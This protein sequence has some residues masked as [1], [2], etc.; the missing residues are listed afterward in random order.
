MQGFNYIAWQLCQQHCDDWR[1]FHL[2]CHL[3]ER[4]HSLDYF[5][6]MQGL[7]RDLCGIAA[8]VQE[9]FP[10]LTRRLQRWELSLDAVLTSWLVCLFTAG[11][12]PCALKG[13]LL[14]FVA[15]RGRPALLQLVLLGLERLSK[16]TSS[17][18]SLEQLAESIRDAEQCFASIDWAEKALRV[19]LPPA[20]TA[21]P[22]RSFVLAGRLSLR[23]QLKPRHFT[24]IGASLPRSASPLRLRAPKSPSAGQCR[25]ED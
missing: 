2:L 24:R 6:G 17:A 15:A 1:V 4:V 18:Q 8:A 11:R 23:E 12:L 16:S 3:L 20:L 5:D 9:R 14:D 7:L 21:S 19:S 25:K 10:R 22:P 13:Q